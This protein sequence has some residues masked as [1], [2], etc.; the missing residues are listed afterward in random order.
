MPE[1][2]KTE[3]FLALAR[4]RWD[5]CEENE[6]EMRKEAK[7]DLE[8][9]A[10]V[11]NFQ[12][13]A[14]IKLRRGNKPCLSLNV[15]PARERQILNDQ[16]QNR[17]QVKVSPVDDKADKDTAEIFEG[18]FRH[19]WYDS[20]AD[21]AIDTGF[22][23]AVR[24]GFGCVEVCNEYEDYDSDLQCIKI[25]RIRNPF[26]VYFDPD[27]QTA[28]YSDAK[29][30]FRFV[31]MAREDFEADY[32]D[33]DAASMTDWT[34]IGDTAPGWFDSDEKVRIARYYVKEQKGRSRPVIK[35]YIING[36]EILG[37]PTTGEKETIIPGKYIPLVPILGDEIDIDGKRVLEGMVRHTRDAVRMSNYMASGLAGAIAYGNNQG[38]KAAVGQITP[39]LE[40]TWTSPDAQ[41]RLY[42]P[43]DVNGKFLPAP[44]RD[45]A[46]PPIQAIAEA[47]A[48]FNEDIKSITGIEDAQLGRR[49]NEISGRAIEQRKT[50]GEVG[51]FHFVDNLS[52]AIRQIGRVVLC[53]APEVY[54]SPRVMR[55]IGE[56]GSHDTVQINKL[57]DEGGKSKKY[58]LT[59][60]KYDVIISA[61]AGYATRRKEAAAFLSETIKA[62]PALMSTSADLV[63]GQMDIAGA[64]ELSERQKKVIAMQF[65]GLI[66][67]DE[68]EQIPP[69]AQQLIAQKTKEAQAMH[70]YAQQVEQERNQLQQEKQGNIIDNQFKVKIKQMD[71]A[72]K[73]EDR[74]LEWAKLEVETV[75]PEI[76]TKAQEPLVRQKLEGDLM[77]KLHVKAADFAMQKDAQGH[78]VGTKAMDQQHDQSMTSQQQAHESDQADKQAEFTAQQADED[79]AL[80]QEQANASSNNS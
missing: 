80:Q 27:C 42:N 29:F 38:W 78:E 46:E 43:M 19:I 51:N 59:V 12:W 9:R 2:K 32:P 40:K 72:D 21:V 48:L 52:R 18:I 47:R 62:F 57:F 7:Y 33:S 45:Y 22:A 36:C 54:D 67:D 6:R 34:S 70:A 71:M 5:A 74:K 37:D 61:E 24:G 53:M 66:E 31:W 11:D 76:T 50:Q 75:M 8:F 14:A 16:R 77:S 49:S 25:E 64:D 39:E 60:G 68:Q 58:D 69:Q 17:P 20:D 23:S 73:A 30:A 79:R 63:F 15:L 55:I 3:D 65:P 44:E 4:K 28:D 41:I 10:N 56:D 35:L 1:D 26:S 13:D